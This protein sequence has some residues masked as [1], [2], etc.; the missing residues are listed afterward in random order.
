M[1]IDWKSKVC[2]YKAIGGSRYDDLY[3]Y[4]MSTI[5]INLI[6]IRESFKL[7]N[8][9]MVHPL[10]ESIMYTLITSHHPK[11]NPDM[12]ELTIHY[13]QSNVSIMCP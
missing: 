1:V 11:F 2:A 12:P 4:S 7:C 10:L 3:Q 6:T 8:T 13:A 9:C 5:A